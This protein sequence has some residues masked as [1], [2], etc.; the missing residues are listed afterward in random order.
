MNFHIISVLNP[1]HFITS[2]IPSYRLRLS[3]VFNAAK[4]LEIRVPIVARLAG[5]NAEKGKKILEKSGLKIISALDLGDA[6]KKIV[7]SVS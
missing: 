1:N 3:Y 4:E 5:T 6:A 7:N 2:R